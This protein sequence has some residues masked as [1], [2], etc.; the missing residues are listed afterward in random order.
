MKNHIIIDSCVYL[1]YA[2]FKKLYRISYCVLD[3]GLQVYIDSNLFDELKKNLPKV[4][5]LNGHN[6][7]EALDEI[8]K[9]TTLVEIIP[10][11]TKSP[12][13]KDN[14]LFDLAIQTQ[15]EVIV[16]KEKV[17]LSFKESPVPIHDIKWFKETYPVNL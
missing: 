14:F 9:F 12:D 16:T 17:L 1:S 13:T 11:Y 15:S 4:L 2:R 3:Y 8:E 6:V 5:F 7:K 10:I